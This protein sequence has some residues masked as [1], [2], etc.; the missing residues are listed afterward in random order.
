MKGCMDAFDKSG[1]NETRKQMLRH[2]FVDFQM[3]KG[4]FSL[5]QAKNDVVFLDAITWWSLYGS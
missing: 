4:L 3:K 1:E 5:P 2:Q